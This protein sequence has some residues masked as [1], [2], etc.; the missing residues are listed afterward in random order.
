MNEAISTPTQP[1][2]QPRRVAYQSVNGQWPDGS[3][4]GRD[5]K[6]TPK[7]A[8]AGAK[9]LYRIAMGKPWTG[10]IKLTSGRRHTWI[11]RGVFYVNPDEQRWSGSG[12]WHEIVHSISHLAARRL[13]GEAHG[14]RH[15]W[16]ERQLIQAV[17]SRGWLQGKLTREPKP[18]P[19]TDPRQEKIKRILASLKR[20]QSKAKRADT[21]I[22]KLERQRRYYERG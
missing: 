6:P 3:N 15:A 21:A 16:I 7:E 8:L 5:L 4:D 13:Y 9:R 2:E 11:R 10:P 12:G 22:R 17:V 14:S 18:K 19:P 1:E 20:W